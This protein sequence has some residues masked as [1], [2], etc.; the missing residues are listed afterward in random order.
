M[1]PAV[2]Q[3]S[4]LTFFFRLIASGKCFDALFLEEL[5]MFDRS[6][7]LWPLSRKP[8]RTFCIGEVKLLTAQLALVG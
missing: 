1:I 4:S 8:A 6:Q 7:E 5:T 2:Y 3:L